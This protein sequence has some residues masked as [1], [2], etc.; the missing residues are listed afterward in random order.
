M[1]EEEERVTERKSERESEGRGRGGESDG[2][3]VLGTEKWKEEE[4]SRKRK[5]EF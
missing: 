2:E 5:C 1:K 3:K 4:K